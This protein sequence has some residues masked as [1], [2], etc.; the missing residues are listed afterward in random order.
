M[1]RGKQ[2]VQDLLK[3]ADIEINGS[4]PWDLQVHNEQLYQRVLTKGSLGFGEAYMDGWWDCDKIDEFICRVVKAGLKDKVNYKKLII[5]FISATIFNVAN[6]KRALKVGKQ[7]YDA[8][9]D[10]YERMLDKHMTYTCGYWKNAKNLDQAQEAK[11]ELTCKK[12]QLKPGMTVLDIGCGWGS[13]AKYAAKKYKVKVVGVT[14]SQ[15]QVDLGNKRCKGLPVEIRFQDYRDVNEKFDR[16]VSFGMFEH[17]GHKN[18]RTFMKVVNR[19]LKDDGMF[20]LQTI[21]FPRSVKTVDPW[22]EKYIF[23]NSMLPSVKQISHAAEGLFV[24]ED[25]HNF[26]I[27][28]EKTLMSWFN[29]FDKKWHEIK[30]NYND[31]FYRMWKFYLLSCAGAFR[32][33]YI[34]LWQIVFSK[35]GIEGGHVSVR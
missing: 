14:I 25:L 13:F 22:I 26:G 32:A 16:I 18:Y 23:P 35:K 15:N 33:R 2:L 7:H 3:E 24:I 1:V 30:Q 17:V 34:Q 28:Y 5:P 31:E 12:I 8:G 20:L 21:G 19:C 10:L 4:R 27:D 29:N 11:F 9:N 6:K